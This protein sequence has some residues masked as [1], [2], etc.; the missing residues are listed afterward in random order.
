MSYRVFI[1]ILLLFVG[2]ET[3]E[4]RTKQIEDRHIEHCKRMLPSH[5]QVLE[6]LDNGWMYIAIDGR[7]YLYH[8]RYTGGNGA[9]ET[10]V[11]VKDYNPNSK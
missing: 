10:M 11:E 4:D 3:K 2:C 8:F 7:V 5:T 6:T 9:V 1:L